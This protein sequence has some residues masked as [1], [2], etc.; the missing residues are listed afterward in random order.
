VPIPENAEA[1]YTFLTKNGYSDNAAAGIVGNIEQ[2]SGG[3]PEEQGGGLIQILGSEGGTLAEQLKAI[4]AYN[5]QQGSNLIS[6]LNA[7]PTP[8]AAALFY[9]NQFERPLASAA[10]NPNREQSAEEVAAAAKSG[11]WPTGPGA[12]GSTSSA[13]G[14]QPTSAITISGISGLL[15][16]VEPLIHGVAIVLDRFFGLFARGQQWRIAFGLGAIVILL[17]AVKTYTGASVS[18]GPVS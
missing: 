13:S 3:N 5:N 11:K 9:S 10:N 15:K 6:E 1:I 14:S 2:E 17:L 8:Q 7:Q 16:N 18:I 4:L 12:T